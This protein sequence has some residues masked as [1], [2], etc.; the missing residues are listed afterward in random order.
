[1][2]LDAHSILQAI[3]IYL[4][5]LVNPIIKMIYYIC[6]CAGRDGILSGMVRMLSLI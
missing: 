6:E 5:T 3:R 1:M 4:Y 2:V